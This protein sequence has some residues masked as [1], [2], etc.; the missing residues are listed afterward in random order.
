MRLPPEMR[1]PDD[2]ASED[3][4]QV[5]GRMPQKKKRKYGSMASELPPGQDHGE[6]EAC[7]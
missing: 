1:T 6:D 7:R 4:N 2:S 5:Q 3:E